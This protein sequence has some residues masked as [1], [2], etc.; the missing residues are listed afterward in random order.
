METKKIMKLDIQ[1]FADSN[2]PAAN[3]I[4]TNAGSVETENVIEDVT[5]ESETPVNEQNNDVE[6]VEESHVKKSTKD[7][8]DRLKADREKIRKELE[9]ENNKRMDNIAKSRGFDNWKEL[10]EYSNKERLEELGVSDSAAFEKYLNN[11]IENNPEIVKAR[12]IIAEQKQKEAERQLNE[13]LIEISKLDNSIKNINDLV[14]HQSYDRVLDRVTKGSSLIDAFKLEN[15]DALTGRATDAA[16]QHTLN[17]INNKSHVKT[18]AGGSVDDIVV[19]NDIYAT[20][21]RNL[22]NWSDEQIKQHYAKELKG[23]N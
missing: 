20:Y 15:F 11:I 13:Q 18:T 3:E 10:E 14:A 22:P 23:D 19:P 17:N 5:T 21:K 16:V 6:I 12:A 7:Y 4:D 2:D 1:L 8:S 9:E